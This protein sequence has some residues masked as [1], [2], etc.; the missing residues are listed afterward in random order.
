MDKISHVKKI[1]V[2]RANALGDFIFALPAL[3]A[4]KRTYPKAEL[5]LL[6]KK[7]HKDFLN[8]RPSPVDR[9]IVVPPFRGVSE[10]DTFTQETPKEVATFFQ[11][12]QK[13]H[14][15]IAIQIHGGGRNSNPFLINLGARITVGTRTQDAPLL[16]RWLPYQYYQNETLRYLEV[17]KLIGATTEEIVPHIT[18]T[19][20][21]TREAQVFL[22]DSA[23]VILHPGATD[24]GRRW[25]PSNFAKVGDALAQKGYHIIITGTSREKEIVEEVMQ[26]M[27]HP[28]I[29]GVDALSLGGFAAALSAASVVIS[30]DTGPLHLANAVGAKTVG[31][32]WCGNLINSDPLNRMHHRPLLSWTIHC[33]LCGMNIAKDF[34]FLRTPESCQHH[35][36]FVDS[37]TTNQVLFEALSLLSPS[38]KSTRN[39]NVSQSL[40]S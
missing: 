16:D 35:T 24:L 37:I 1:A 3:S 40:L 20:D 23:F 11:K 31:I 29:N 21:D 8:N 32:Y 38:P 36:S 27:H 2:L 26:C 17:V 19:K 28:A 34:P 9:V 18:V 5:V 12:M 14:F 39:N 7:W 6:G 33:P 15:D 22:P 30:N 25:S 13:E 10:P 4:L